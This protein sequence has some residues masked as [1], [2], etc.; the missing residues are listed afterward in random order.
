MFN[1]RK[2]KAREMHTTSAI[3]F[4]QSNP[5]ARR[6]VCLMWVCMPMGRRTELWLVQFVDSTGLV[7]RKNRGRRNWNIQLQIGAADQPPESAVRIECDKRAD[8]MAG[9]LLKFVTSGNPL[10]Q[11]NRDIKDGIRYTLMYCDKGTQ[12]VMTAAN[13]NQGTPIMNLIDRLEAFFGHCG[14]DVS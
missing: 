8:E 1:W 7:W 6:V 12:T 4:L 9:E 10:A 2:I 14:L 11:V 3:R 13:P 5:A